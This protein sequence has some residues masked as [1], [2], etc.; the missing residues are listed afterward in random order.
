V[1]AAGFRVGG[2]RWQLL[3]GGCY[4]TA[5]G[6]GR[7]SAGFE[8]PDRQ[9][10]LQSFRSPTNEPTGYALRELAPAFADA[11]AQGKRTAVRAVTDVAWHRR[12]SEIEDDAMR[13]ALRARGFEVH[14]ATGPGS[15]FFSWEEPA[16]RFLKDRWAQAEIRD[17]LFD[18]VASIEPPPHPFRLRYASDAQLVED[19]FNEAWTNN[20]DGSYMWNPG[21]VL[22]LASDL[23]NVFAVG[24]VPRRRWKEL[25]R[26]STT[27]RTAQDWWQALRSAFDVLLNRAVRQRNAIIHGHDLVP[28]VIASVEPFVAQLSGYLAY[29]AV[30]AA[31]KGRDMD[32][33]LEETRAGLVESFER[34]RS[35]PLGLALWPESQP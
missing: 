2:T 8:D 27:G 29:L 26:F 16:R 15:G 28:E 10:A 17:S 12:A 23:S 13:L 7:G 20:P 6:G 31:E 9:K 32:D 3:D 22:R 21:T 35:E 33:E 19:A 5:E 18:A 24:S 25:A 1:E 11:L 30:E 34:L 4:F 14:W